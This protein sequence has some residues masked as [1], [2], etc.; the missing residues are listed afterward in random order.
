LPE[1]EQ[2]VYIRIAETLESFDDLDDGVICLTLEGVRKAM[3][4][5]EALWKPLSEEKT[6]AATDL[7]KGTRTVE[8]PGR[9]DPE[10]LDSIPEPITLPETRLVRDYIMAL[11]KHESSIIKQVRHAKKAHKVL[12]TLNPVKQPLLRASAG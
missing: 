3:N 1:T 4:M 8:V 5:T 12:S 7:V 2:Q 6:R 9:F 10:K 11:C